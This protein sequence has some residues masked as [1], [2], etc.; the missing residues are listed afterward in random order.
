MEVGELSE[1]SREKVDSA[2]GRSKV[3]LKIKMNSESL[4]FNLE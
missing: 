3:V 1:T 2:T 4:N